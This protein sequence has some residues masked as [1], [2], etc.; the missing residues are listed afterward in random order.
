MDFKNNEC[1]NLK[2]KYRE[3]SEGNIWVFTVFSLRGFSGMTMKTAVAK[4]QT[5]SKWEPSVFQEDTFKKFKRHVN[6]GR[7]RFANH[8]KI[9]N[10]YAV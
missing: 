3:L 6:N 9:F 7:I 5:S 8:I 2:T 4:D 1:P 10:I